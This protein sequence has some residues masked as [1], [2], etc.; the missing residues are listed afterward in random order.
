MISS[1]REIGDTVGLASSSTV[2]G[3]LDR[4]G[5]RGLIRRDPSKPRVIEVVD[6]ESDTINSLPYPLQHVS[7]LGKVIGVF[8][9]WDL[10]L[11]TGNY[12]LRVFT[13]SNCMQSRGTGAPPKMPPRC[14]RKDKNV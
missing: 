1:V 4:L 2:H 6:M 3:H 11:K 14:P 8:R 12:K 7:I 9:N 10:D 5:K 13:V